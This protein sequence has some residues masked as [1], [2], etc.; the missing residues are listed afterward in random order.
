[1]PLWSALFTEKR[2]GS[3]GLLTMQALIHLLFVPQTLLYQ[4]CTLFDRSIYFINT[5]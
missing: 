5:L 2:G 1:M 4:L 3:A